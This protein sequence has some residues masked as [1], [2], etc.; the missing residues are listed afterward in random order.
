MLLKF[1]TSKHMNE[2]KKRLCIFLHYFTGDYLPIYVQYYLNELH[3]YFD[4]VK[5]VTNERRINRNPTLLNKK[6]H[7]QFVKNGGYDF[8]LFYKGFQNIN[9]SEYC[10]IACINDSNIV[11][12]KLEFL[13]NW[14]D[15]QL[16]D[17]WG[18]VDS[19]EKPWFSNHVNNYHIQSHFVVFNTKAIDL[20]PEFFNKMSYNQLI[21]EADVKKLRRKI[22]TQW[23]IGLTQFWLSH[24]LTCLTYIDSQHVA[25]Q[26][27]VLKP[28][29]VFNKHYADF[30]E[31]GIPFIKK[32]LIMHSSWKNK[33][34]FRNKWHHL[35]KKYGETNWEIDLLIDDLN[36]MK[37]DMS[38]NSLKYLREKFKKFS[39]KKTA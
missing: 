23:E 37:D 39:F 12:G 21:M 26:K 29:N 27:G 15:K 28:I 11:F 6:T 36:L 16:V 20:L 14:S 5:M 31:D 17:V 18:L 19:H 32:R 22:I 13:F 25:I 8:G 1:N 9:P 7:I 3:H 2:R 35:I 24:G 34:R 4:E 33:L 10:K 38:P 30:I